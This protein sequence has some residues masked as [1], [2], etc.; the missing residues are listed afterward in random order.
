[1]RVERYFEQD[2]GTE[3]SVWYKYISKLVVEE[4]DESK[5]V[6]IYTCVAGA[7]TADISSADIN[8]GKVYS[9]FLIRFLFGKLRKLLWYW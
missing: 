3:W 4:F 2:F 5:D 9:K 8:I 6:G 1:M 7:G